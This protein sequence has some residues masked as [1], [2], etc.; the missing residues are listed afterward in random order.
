MLRVLCVH[1]T[2]KTRKELGSS[3]SLAIHPSQISAD[4]IGSAQPIAL[5]S[6]MSW[7]PQPAVRSSASVHVSFKVRCIEANSQICSCRRG[8]SNSSMA[9]VCKGGKNENAPRPC[10]CPTTQPARRNNAVLQPDQ[11]GRP[12]VARTLCRRR[13]H[14]TTPVFGDDKSCLPRQLPKHTACHN[15]QSSKTQMLPKC[16]GVENG[17]LL[18]YS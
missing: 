4:S 7:K 16:S 2:V 14:A 5:L 9:Y 8:H 12:K 18:G 6:K 13:L 15:P 17:L 3:G 1:C 10:Q 11:T